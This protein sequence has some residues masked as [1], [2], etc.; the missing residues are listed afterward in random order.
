[1]FV[2]NTTHHKLPHMHKGMYI[3]RENVLSLMGNTVWVSLKVV[4]H[5]TILD[6]PN[7]NTTKNTKTN[8]HKHKTTLLCITWFMFFH[9]TLNL[10]LWQLTMTGDIFECTY[11]PKTS[12]NFIASV[13]FHEYIKSTTDENITFHNL[14]DYSSNASLVYKRHYNS[15]SEIIS[16]LLTS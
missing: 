15:N 2:H 8:P 12:L 14:N 11:C 5:C 9:N 13:I 3:K 6:H 1:M 16:I 7:T 10:E 4:V